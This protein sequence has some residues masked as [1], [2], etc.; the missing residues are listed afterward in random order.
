ML[1]HG[2]YSSNHTITI[3]VLYLVIYFVLFRKCNAKKRQNITACEKWCRCFMKKYITLFVSLFLSITGFAQPLSTPLAYLTAMNKAHQTLNYE[4]LYIFQKGDDV[5]SLRYRHAYDN[6]QEYAQLLHLDATREEM[7]LREDVVG[8]FGDYQPFS[9]KTP[10]ILDDF[11]TVV[12]SDFSQLEGYAF[13]DNGKSRVADRIARVIRIVPRD[14]FRY[15]YMLWI[16]EENHLLLQSHLLDRDNNVLEQFRTIQS[17]VDEQ[18]LYI[19]EPIRTLILPTLLQTKVHSELK[20][21]EWQ[22]KWV[23][24]GF[25]QVASGQQN[26]SEVLAQDEQI[27]SR[28]YSDGLFSFTVYLVQNKGI[29]FQ[30][31]FWREGKT[32]VYSQTIGDK[33]VIIV[34]EIPLASA[35]HIVQEI[36]F[37]SQGE[38]Q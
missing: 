36:E 22:L 26:L 18:L 27:E 24:N 11:P 13:L 6:G 29:S 19:V 34:G 5:T 9:L 32:S 17:V 33:D 8:Y 3:L 4:Q 38:E 25:K 35:R 37:S 10:H 30:D 7:I 12:Y 2:V 1:G 14:D 28:L 23:P 20:P 16:D 21:L 15:Q 31:Q